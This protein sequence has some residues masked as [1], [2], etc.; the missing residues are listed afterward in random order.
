MLKFVTLAKVFLNFK[1]G[2]LVCVF[3][4]CKIDQLG[5]NLRRRVHCFCGCCCQ[6]DIAALEVVSISVLHFITCCVMLPSICVVRTLLVSQVYTMVLTPI[7]N[8]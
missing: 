3:C 4:D 6:N 7:D 2:Y 5:S 8:T 1:G